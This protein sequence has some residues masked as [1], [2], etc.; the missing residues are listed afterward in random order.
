MPDQNGRTPDRPR[1]S[2]VAG[3]AVQPGADLPREHDGAVR[4]RG[5]TVLSPDSVIV[6]VTARTVQI[7]DCILIGGQPRKVMNIRAVHGG[8]QLSLHTG[9]RLIIALREEYTVS[10][11]V[12]KRAR[13]EGR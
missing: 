9:E 11:P 4:H 6:T 10:R 2:Y 7:R 1:T 3:R 5:A 8:S 12:P 13:W